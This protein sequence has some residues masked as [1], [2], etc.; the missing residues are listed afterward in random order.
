MKSREHAIDFCTEL[1]VREHLFED[2]GDIVAFEIMECPHCSTRVVPMEDG[3]CPACRKNTTDQ[4]LLFAKGNQETE[5]SA[6]DDYQASLR[7]RCDLP[8]IVEMR[9][10]ENP[11]TELRTNAIGQL[12]QSLPVDEQLANRIE[13][14][15][16]PLLDAT[17]H[18]FQ[19][20]TESNETEK[21]QPTDLE[22]LAT[23]RVE[24]WR[25]LARAIRENNL[26]ILQ[27]HR[28]R[29]EASELQLIHFQAEKHR[30]PPA[31]VPGRPRSR[32]IVKTIGIVIAVYGILS[33]FMI[34]GNLENQQRI[35]IGTEVGTVFVVIGTAIYVLAPRSNSKPSKRSGNSRRD[36]A[37]QV[38]AFE[39]ALVTFTPRVIVIPIIVLTNILIF[40]L[41]LADGV[42][43]RGWTP[44]VMLG[45][46]GNFGPVTR[47]GEWWRLVSSM[48][49]HYGFFHLAFNMLA[50]VYFGRIVERLLG[51]VG[52]LV[53]Y[54]VA[55]IGGSIASVAWRTDVVSAG[56][57]GAV[58]G[59][60]GALI[61]FLVW[62]RDTIPLPVLK[63]L[64]NGMISFLA[65][66]MYY[67][68]KQP[69]I[70]MAAHVGGLIAGFLCGLVLS[71]PLA[72]GMVANRRQKNRLVIAGSTVAFPVLATG[73]VFCL[74]S[75]DFHDRRGLIYMEQGHY[76]RAMEEINRSIELSPRRAASYA[77]RGKLRSILDDERGAIVDLDQAI[78]LSP[79][80]F[81]A[82][83]DRGLARSTLGDHDMAIA[84]F[85][86]GLNLVPTRDAASRSAFLSARAIVWNNK[87][88]LDTAIAD[89]D[90]A[91]RLQPDNSDAY[92]VRAYAYLARDQYDLVISDCNQAIRRDPNNIA[93]LLYRGKAFYHKSMYEQAITDFTEIISR[94]TT[95]SSD[96]ILDECYRFRGSARLYQL[97]DLRGAVN[98][99]SEALRRNDEDKF[100]L[101]CRSIIYASGPKESL[102]NGKKAVE[103]ATRAC[104][105][106]D[107][108]NTNYVIALAAGY[109]ETGQFELAIE[110]Q[111]KALKMAEPD[112][113]QECEKRLTLY[114]QS[115]PYRLIDPDSSGGQGE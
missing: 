30:E 104:E 71:Q 21:H 77:L 65:I 28:D 31:V 6:W 58:Y 88:L 49:L 29:W 89:A 97:Q 108:K 103:D 68:I 75:A 101:W 92:R 2:E 94:T 56:A 64:R 50:L 67:G 15:L 47:A 41:M 20:T 23:D 51:N 107:W 84:D 36:S 62:R 110:W 114:E 93:A 25:L 87:N 17:F 10:I 52:F 1:V 91:I 32:S 57:S 18:R 63:R 102:R 22:S 73:I 111:T 106:A 98:D 5:Q 105:L 19:P 13:Q 24:S 46:G 100:S 83:Y 44:E 9:N 40:V 53:T 39:Q 99:F 70:D 45:W 60:A 4:P 109:A 34:A 90:E 27:Q 80:T 78:Q 35:I 76:D 72:L 37:Q 85:N 38:A 74:D 12:T 59:I 82:L 79:N 66:E 42:A 95:T 43:I 55:G 48:F 33:A 112:D 54:F 96:D 26:E 86:A 11:F 14:E 7:F 115:K 8:L 16:I 81:D 69:Q 3:I 61:G 113:K